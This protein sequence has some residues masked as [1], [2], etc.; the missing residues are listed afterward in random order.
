MDAAT[1]TGGLPGSPVMAIRPV[2]AWMMGS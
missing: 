2:N 1:R